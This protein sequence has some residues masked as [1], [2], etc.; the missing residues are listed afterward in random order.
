MKQRDMEIIL[1]V[2]V[3]VALVSLV[4]GVAWLSSQLNLRVGNYKLHVVFDNIGTL[5]AGDHVNMH[6]IQVGKVL[7]A[8]LHEGSPTAYVAIW[9]VQGGV[10]KDSRFWLKS[11]SL[12]GGYIIDIDLGESPELMP[13]EAFTSGRMYPGFENLAS[14]AK[15]L[16]DR[17]TDPR[18]GV[19][20]EANVQRIGSTL[21]SLDSAT[22]SLKQVLRATREPLSTLLD[23]LGGASSEMKGALQEARAAMVDT[24]PGVRQALH[25]LSRTT[26]RLDSLTADL[27]AASGSLKATS[28]NLRDITARI[29]QGQGT[30]GKLLTDDRL[31]GDLRKTLAQVDT[32]LVDL[33]RDPR[34]YIKISIF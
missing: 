31:Y 22:A 30:L 20:S 11:E 25:H 14:D 7:K 26:A 21:A 19:L 15:R 28:E 4:V 32:I 33:Q 12:L 29:R 24:R 3:F 1:G 10:P 5:H 17:L 13:S 6:G 23:S 27:G 34:R 16:S 8:E 9:G 18:S 2:V